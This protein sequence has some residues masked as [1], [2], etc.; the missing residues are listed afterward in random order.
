[1]EKFWLVANNKENLQL[2][3][4]TTSLESNIPE[5]IPS[6]MIVDDEILESTR[7]DSQGVKKI[8]ELNSW[9]E[10]ANDKVVPKE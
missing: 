7:K 4:K 1:M 10:E 6:S 9:D 2:L 5:L 8:A 3:A